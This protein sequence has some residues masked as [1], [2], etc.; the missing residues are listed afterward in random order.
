MKILYIEDNHLNFRLVQKMLKGKYEVSGAI[1]GA[2]GLSQAAKLMPDLILLDI[3]LPDFD[4]FKVQEQLQADSRFKHIPIIAL[5]ANSMFGDRKRILEA[6][7]DAYLAKPITRIEL[8]KTVIKHI[9][10]AALV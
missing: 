3:N 4:G 7:F 1:T 8:I 6:G 9:P 10:T 5:T 2:E